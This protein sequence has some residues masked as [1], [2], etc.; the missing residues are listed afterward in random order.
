[1]RLYFN[2][3][4]PNI[5]SKGLVNNN[6]TIIP[7]NIKNEEPTSS[8][9]YT[10]W[11]KSC[12]I[13]KYKFHANPI[14]HYR[15]QY[16]DKDTNNTTSFS[17]LSLKGNIDKPGANIVTNIN[18]PNSNLLNCN[19]SIYTYLDNDTNCNILVNDKLYDPLLNKTICTSFNPTA[20]IIKTATTNLSNTYASSHRQHLYNKYKTFN[21]NLPLTTNKTDVV[22]NG[23]ITTIC[24][25]ETVCRT[26][27]PSNKNSM[28]RTS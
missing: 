26:F 14:R 4:T 24:N 23:T 21:Q 10:Q 15:K 11:S 16:V 17:N 20:L 18:T 2:Q 28:S 12:P 1:M 3:I 7:K 6:V 27:N 22:T 9:T 5:V 25:G 8:N 13:K 19:L